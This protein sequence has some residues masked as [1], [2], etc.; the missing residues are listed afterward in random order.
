MRSCWR[1]VAR[2]G[3]GC[4]TS[5]ASRRS[6][7]IC[8]IASDRALDL[9]AETFAR[10]LEAPWAVR[11][12]AQHFQDIADVLDHLSVLAIEAH[13]STILPGLLIRPAA[14]AYLGQLDELGERRSSTVPASPC[15]RR[16]QARPRRQWS[17]TDTATYVSSSY[18]ARGKALAHPGILERPH[19][20]LR[21]PDRVDGAGQHRIERRDLKRLVIVRDHSG[22]KR[23]GLIG[24]E[25]PPLA[26]DAPLLELG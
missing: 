13:Q 10:A 18:S 21:C 19:R 25:H 15:R 7:R 5:V 14:A 22:V 24:R 16:S 26:D 12:G 17:R 6:E 8:A 2:R 4:F 3:S 9:V 1:V 23:A 20:H 11:P